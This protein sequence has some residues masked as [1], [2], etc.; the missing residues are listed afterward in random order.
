MTAKGRAPGINIVLA[1]VQG[2]PNYTFVEV[3]YDDGRSLSLGTWGDYR[4]GDGLAVI[5][6]TADEFAKAIADE[7]NS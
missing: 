6:V 2:T 5:R 4:S 3:E 7:V 1:P